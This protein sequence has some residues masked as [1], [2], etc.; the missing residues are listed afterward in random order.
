MRLLFVARRYWPAV[1]GVESFVR[2]LGH[3]LEK[4]H[5]ITVLA[6]RIDAGL[7]TRLTDSLA[8]PP[9][10]EPFEDE[11]VRVECL[12]IPAARRA[13]MAPLLLD[14]VP[15]SRRYAYGRAR[16]ASAWLYA[17]AVAPTIAR[18][19]H[20]ADVL[21]M[22]GGDY[23]AAAAV[24]AARLAGVPSVVTPFAHEGQWG[25]DPGSAAAYR[26]ADS[27]IGLLDADAGLYRRLGASDGKVR[28]CGVCSPGVPSGGGKP[29]RS[30]A[31][32]Q[33]PLILFLG[34]RR[35]YKGFDLLLRA[36]PLVSR[37]HPDVTFA[38]AGPGPAI[39]DAPPGTRV[40]DLG[41]LDTAY[42]AAWLEA[43]D[44]LCLPSAGE[45]FPVSILE[46]WS[47][48]TPVITSDIS[49]LV[50]LLSR[51]GGGLTVP[52]T[53]QSLADALADALDNPRRLRELGAR[54]R[55]YWGEHGT[56]IAVAAWHENLYKELVSRRGH[57][58][59]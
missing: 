49:P 24:R 39:S 17:H 42:C 50:E 9:A 23:M 12:R 27:V 52:R 5:E 4:R 8:P 1:G 57:P 36:A 53:V 22:W 19:A 35:P 7:A 26:G 45:I 41:M 58:D 6:H 55:A 28:V 32:V 13:A 51:S 10:F 38:F 43:A 25:D 18:W 54:G 44:V 46:A 47:V 14:V 40:I 31:A 21:H 11:G 3:E 59:A 29:V 2:Q 48:G 34:V 33:G 30:S 15:G 16:R 20:G 56:P 37:R